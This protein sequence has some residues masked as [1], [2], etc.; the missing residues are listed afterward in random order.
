MSRSAIPYDPLTAE[1]LPAARRESAPTCKSRAAAAAPSPTPAVTAKAIR[2]AACETNADA[3]VRRQHTTVC[4]RIDGY[5]VWLMLLQWAAAIATALWIS[6]LAWPTGKNSPYPHLGTAH[7]TL[8][9][10]YGG[11]LTLVPIALTRVAPGR[12]ITRLTIAVA[13]MLMGSLLIHLTGGRIETHFHTF[14][15]LAFL[16]FYIDWQVLVAASVTIALDRLL[17]GVY[18]PYSVFGVYAVQP[19]RWLEHAGWV[20]FCDV[21]LIAAC[22]ARLTRFHELIT[23]H[24]ERGALLHRAY[25]DPLTGLPNRTFLLEKMSEIICESRQASEQ[26]PS[27]FES[28]FACL[29]VD[30]DQFQDVNDLLGHARGDSLLRAI[31]ERLKS[32]LGDQVFLSRVAIVPEPRPSEPRDTSSQMVLTL[33][34]V[35]LTGRAEE[36]ARVILRSLLQPFELQGTPI[37]VGAGIGISHFPRHGQD[38]AEILAHSEKAMYR[39]KRAGRNDYLVYSPELFAE[40]A[41]LHQAESPPPSRNRRAPTPT[42]LPAHLPRR[43]LAL[44]PRG[45]PP[46]ARSSP[47]QHPPPATSSA[48]PKPPASSSS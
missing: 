24:L 4:A 1:P 40:S 35:S 29:Y 21:F 7:L 31:A 15:S 16:A 6:P 38:E 30:L 9:L 14:G 22:V 2:E 12:R 47:R 27:G 13:Q 10:L 3:E 11:V 23:R 46:L 39:A 5:F 36:A 33:Q 48:S 25:Y 17:R 34:S 32:R 41:E 28:A 26:E 43:W 37:T 18:L 42:P 8:A 44:R 20:L 45:P 19:W